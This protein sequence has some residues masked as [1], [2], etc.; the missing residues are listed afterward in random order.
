MPVLTTERLTEL[1]TEEGV[2]VVVMMVVVMV[3][4]L[5]PLSLLNTKKTAGQTRLGLQQMQEKVQASAGLAPL[6]PEEW[7]GCGGRLCTGWPNLR[8]QH[9]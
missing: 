9:W 6:L 4:E 2:V 8:D 5:S 3:P 7:Y 1:W